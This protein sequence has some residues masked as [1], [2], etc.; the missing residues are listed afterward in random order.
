MAR[1][2]SQTEDEASL[3]IR[4]AWL[5]FIGGLTQGQ[6]AERLGV[7]SVKAHRLITRA[8]QIGAVKVS[9]EGDVAECVRLEVELSARYGLDYCEVVPDIEL[10]EAPLR[11]LGAAGA[12]FLR[13]EIEAH[14]NSVI[15][16]GNG[17]TL[18]A[19][20]SELRREAAP[21]VRFVSLLGGLTR[22]YAA[23][24]FDVMHRLAEKTH[25]QAWTMPVPFFANT[26]DDRRVLLAQR[27]VQEVLDLAGEAKMLLVG[28]GAV[29]TSA[30]LV[31]A[32]VLE[33]EE[34]EAA[35]A[36]GA[37]GELLGHFFAADGR[38]VATGL[39]ARALSPALDSLHGR[40]VVAVAGGA[41]K[42][43]ALAAVLNGGILKGLV[44]VEQ[45]AR[46]L[47]ERA[48]RVDAQARPTRRAGALKVVK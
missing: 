12:A 33:R 24:P 39:S 16:I 5:H 4:A 13:R 36:E 40:R 21:G 48:E 3:A 32:H 18:S 35:A 30:N 17:R 43:D 28:I 23:N 37:V 8:T 22:N 46:A 31:A 10:H 26:A 6:V 11:E 14:P 1:V 42:T 27:G 15:G 2:P 7:S 44:T 19:V 20:V 9:I 47:V 25:G 41:D 38:V 29:G 45:T 34:I